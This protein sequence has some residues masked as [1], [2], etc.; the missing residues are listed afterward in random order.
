V[1]Q[2]DNWASSPRAITWDESLSFESDLVSQACAVWQAVAGNSIPPRSAITARFSKN[3][4]G[5]M[6]I[7]ERQSTGAFWVRLMGTRVTSVLG[8]MQGK[9]FAEALPADADERW[10]GAL[11]RTLANR[12]PLRVVTVVNLNGL[13]FLE[14]EMVLA[15]L[16]DE[17]GQE[18]MVFAVV[19]FRSGVAKSNAVNE[20][21]HTL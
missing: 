9:T 12:K 6:I 2:F 4:V 15:P 1:T 5:N 3:F 16:C 21:V 11:N 14:A 18:T 7:F 20:L 13:Q 19:V 10:T 8:E 17:H